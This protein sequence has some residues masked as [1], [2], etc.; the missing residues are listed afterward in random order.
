MPAVADTVELHTQGEAK[1]LEV[2]IDP[3]QWKDEEL[4]H[5]HDRDW[6]AYFGPSAS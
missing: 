4:T 2:Y 1:L 3:T 5:R 6:Q